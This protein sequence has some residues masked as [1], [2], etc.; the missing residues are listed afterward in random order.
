MA[1]PFFFMPICR[2]ATYSGLM[3]DLCY[4][5]NH[6]VD[7]FTQRLWCEDRLRTVPHIVPSK[8]VWL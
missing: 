8:I 1:S 3:F 4:E 7:F 5:L 2:G 6:Y